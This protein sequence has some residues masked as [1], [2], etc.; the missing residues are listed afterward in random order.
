M[1]TLTLYRKDSG[2]NDTLGELFDE[3]NKRICNTLEDEYRKLGPKGE[4]KVRGETRIPAGTYRLTIRKALTGLTLKYRKKFS[5]FE[6]HI[7]LENVPFFQ[8]IYIHIGNKEKDTDGC[9][10]LGVWLDRKARFITSSTVT[11]EAFYKKYYPL[12]KDNKDIYLNIV[13]G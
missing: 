10:L 4:G 8:G 12:I 2:I 13:D 6:Y 9:I 11:Y 5:W 3:N 1:A 7:E